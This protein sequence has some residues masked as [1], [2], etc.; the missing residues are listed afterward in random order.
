MRR[1]G[2]QARGFDGV[3][4]EDFAAVKFGD[5]HVSCI[6]DDEHFPCFDCPPRPQMV[7]A[8]IPSDRFLPRLVKIVTAGAGAFKFSVLEVC[9]FGSSHVSVGGGHL[10]ERF[11]W[12]GSVVGVLEVIPLGL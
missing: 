11:V 6:D 1:L 4:A 5:D 10:V 2:Q 7:H 12:A 8:P 9:S 3:L